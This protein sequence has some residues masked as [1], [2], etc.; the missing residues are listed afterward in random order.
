[1]KKYFEYIGTT[2]RTKSGETEKFWEV[3]LEEKT[4]SVRYGKIGANGQTSSKDFPSEDE[5]AK[6]ANKKIAEKTK[7]GYTE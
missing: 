4:V 2:N 7:E 6:Y 5:A 3:S 1:V